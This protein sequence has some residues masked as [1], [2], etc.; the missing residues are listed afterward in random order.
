MMK[1]MQLAC[2]AGTLSVKPGDGWG[3]WMRWQLV[4]VSKM[5]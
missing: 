2:S 4:V 5:G 1:M 3:W